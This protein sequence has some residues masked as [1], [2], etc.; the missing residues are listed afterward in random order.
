MRHPIY[1][2]VPRVAGA[3]I[4]AASAVCALA[5]QTA[6][7]SPHFEAASVKANKSGGTNGMLRREAGGRM[8]AS[9]M[10]LRM[11]ITFAYGLQP[12]RLV[13]GPDWV[14]TERFD[15]VAKFDGDPPPSPPGGP[16]DALTLS[17]RSLLEER[18]HLKLRA[19]TRD[20][21][22]YSL[23]LARSDGK[24]GPGL[25]PTGQDCSPDAM[26]QRMAAGPPAPPGPTGLMDCGLMMNPGRVRSGGMPLS[27]LASVLSGQVGRIVN[28]K[29][30][31]TGGWDFEMTFTPTGNRPPGAGPG[32]VAPIDSD[33][34]SI[35]TALQEQLGLKLEPAKAPVDVFVIENV[36]RPTDD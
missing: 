5:A 9:N 31:L 20:V 6:A 30:G 7:P 25:K 1:T 18:F 4:V 8:E 32:D 16:P 14:A 26:K 29:T 15:I 11:L 21:D 33:A 19:E 17:M 13:G 10:P 27:Q 34:P 22:T 35:F 28:D 36:E 12:F 24:Y 3:V 2:S 23:V